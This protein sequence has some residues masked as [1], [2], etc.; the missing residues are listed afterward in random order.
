M[1]HPKAF[2]GNAVDESAFQLLTRRES[3]GVHQDVQAIPILAERID[4]GLDL[5]I[6]THITGDAQ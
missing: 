1:C 5:L 2:A 4:Q 6:V 3:N